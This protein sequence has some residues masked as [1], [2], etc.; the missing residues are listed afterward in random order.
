[1]TNLFVDPDNAEEEEGMEG[2]EGELEAVICL[3]LIFTLI[4]PWS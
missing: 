3:P 2:I 1:M 4:H